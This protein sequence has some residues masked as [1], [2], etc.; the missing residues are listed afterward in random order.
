MSKLIK[1]VIVRKVEKKSLGYALLRSF[2]HIVHRAS[3]RN[4]H[5]NGLENIPKNKPIIFAA[6]HQNA[7]LDP[8]L[9]IFAT[10]LQ[11]VFLARAD[12]FKNKFIARILN[13]LKIAPVYR[14]RD[15]KESL[16]K[17]AQSFD[18]SVRILKNNRILALFPEG[19]HT[20]QK[21]MLPHKKAIP[22]IVFMAAESTNFEIDIQIVP[23]GINYT[24]Y[25]KFKRN[26][27]INF[28][29]PIS[30]KSYYKR[31]QSEGEVK[32]SNSMRDDLYDAIDKLVVNVPNKAYYNIFE[33]AFETIKQIAANQLKVKNTSRNFVKIEKYISKNISQ[34]FEKFDQQ[35]VDDIQAKAQKYKQL[36]QKTAIEEDAIIKHPVKISTII[37]KT[38]AII[39][40]LPFSVLGILAHGL[41]FYLTRYPIRKFIKD[42]Q[43]YSTFAFGLTLVFY[44]LWIIGLFF[45]LQAI[46]N[47]WLWAFTLLVISFPSGILAWELLQLIRNTIQVIRLRTN[48]KYITELL[49]LRQQL[50]QFYNQFI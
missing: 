12:I 50:I 36:K 3:Y 16:E 6:N 25:Y 5:I 18:T 28:G 15:G 7:L 32:A 31:Y 8:I 10:N 48:N 13:Y 34:L 23:V 44:P 17:N 19:A 35:K 4:L 20:G 24:H 39:I 49:D 37:L 46:F 45:I 22:R 27:V 2:A 43:F 9:I 40:L 14:M 1:I 26:A 41:I 47:S 21:S 29:K 38:L 11:P 42:P 30:T 33:Q